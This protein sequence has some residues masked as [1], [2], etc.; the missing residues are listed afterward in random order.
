MK[1]FA[2]TREY[3]VHLPEQVVADLEARDDASLNELVDKITRQ[4]DEGDLSTL[5]LVHVPGCE[6]LGWVIYEDVEEFVDDGTEPVCEYK[7]EDYTCEEIDVR[8]D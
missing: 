7:A 5:Y 8:I 2:V 4:H 6:D 1:N 3:R